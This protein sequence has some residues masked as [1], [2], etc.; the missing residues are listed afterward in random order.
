MYSWSRKAPNSFECSSKGHKEFSALYAQLSDGRTIEQHYQCDIKGWDIGGRNWKLGK[1]K[2]P[3]HPMSYEAQYQAY[4]ALWKQ[5]LQAHPHLITLIQNSGKTVLTDMFAHTDINQARA[6]AELLNEDVNTMEE[7]VAFPFAQGTVQ[8]LTLSAQ[9]ADQLL[10]LA[11]Q[12]TMT[13]K[14][15][16]RHSAQYG[17]DYSY[18]GSTVKGQ[19]IPA[20]MQ[21]VMHN[22]NSM[23]E[24]DFNS[25]LVNIYPAKTRTG[26]G[27]HKDNEPELKHTNI[28]S[29]SLGGT[30]D[31]IFKSYIEQRIFELKHGDLLYIPSEVQQHYSH[32]IDYGIFPDTRISLT[33]RTFK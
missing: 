15:K 28:A 7:L 3:K 6:I 13:H 12:L 29:I 30:R 20:W 5:Y 2:P 33:F 19:D 18:S 24:M 17:C 26:I 10:V 23:L 21:K 25:C 27:F 31:F 9:D 32:G 8:G 16:V 11:S 4:K 22:L 1:G 14:L